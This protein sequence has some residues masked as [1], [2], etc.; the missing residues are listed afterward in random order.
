MN[1]INRS[2]EINIIAYSI[3]NSNDYIIAKTDS[4]YVVIT[5]DGAMEYSDNE[6]GEIYNID[7]SKSNIERA[8][9]VA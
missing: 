9:W 3:P 1:N 6:M 4:A 2:N 8:G 7:L 5:S